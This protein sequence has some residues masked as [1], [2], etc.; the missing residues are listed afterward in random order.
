MGTQINE[1]PLYMHNT[2]ILYHV[3][4]GIVF[5]VSHHPVLLKPYIRK[6]IHYYYY[7]YN[8]YYYPAVQIEG[9][10]LFLSEYALL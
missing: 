6:M 2:S 1:V 10:R 8:Y 5:L 4:C 3:S 9:K 7:Y